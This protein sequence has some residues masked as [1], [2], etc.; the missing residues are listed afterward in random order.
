MTK[1]TRLWL[2]AAPLVLASGSA[3]RR[4]L[5]EAVGVPLLV[6]PP[7]LD[8]RAFEAPLLQRGASGG[9]LAL[10]LARAKAQ[11]VSHERPDALVLGADQTLTLDRRIF[12][13]P[14]DRR[15]ARSQLEALAGRAHCLF[16]AAAVM[17]GGETLWESVDQATLTMRPLSEAFLDAYL[18]ACGPNVM[19][20][21]GAY[22]VEARG[23][24]LFETIE[25]SHAT[26]LG[27]PLLPLLAFLRSGGYLLA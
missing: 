3:T 21:V 19:T 9:E 8:E 1:D 23:A 2:A 11:T 14:Q 12:S 5:L 18:D 27:L 24:H 4:T 16:A 20:S 25:G 6:V 17:R 7:R 15:Q 10:A 22:Q 13:K 26:V